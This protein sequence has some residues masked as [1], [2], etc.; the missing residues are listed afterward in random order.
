MAAF[1]SATCQARVCGV[2][3]VTV[4]EA[5]DAELETATEPLKTSTATVSEAK[6]LF[7]IDLLLSQ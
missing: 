7:F 6:K 1:H 3:T 2:H 5:A 4:F